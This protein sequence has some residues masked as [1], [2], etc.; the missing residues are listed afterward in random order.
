MVSWTGE[1]AQ[2]HDG[3]CERCAPQRRFEL[4][5]Y[6]TTN[7]AATV[8]FSHNLNTFDIYWGSIDS[9]AG[10]GRDNLLTLSNGD[11]LTATQLTRR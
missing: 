3:E 7:A 4:F 9:L 8:T 11:S 2:R 10:D 6:G 5:A 1:I